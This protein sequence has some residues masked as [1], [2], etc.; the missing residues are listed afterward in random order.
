LFPGGG[1]PIEEVQLY[2]EAQPVTNAIP[3]LANAILCK[4]NRLRR[5]RVARDVNSSL[6]LLAP[7]M[8]AAFP[9]KLSPELE[10]KIAAAV[11]RPK[12]PAR[13]RIHAAFVSNSSPV[14]DEPPRRDLAAVIKNEAPTEAS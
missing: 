8:T 4:S 13:S 12:P 1:I 9:P 11:K 6:L 10:A 3:S 2:Y 14:P 7:E 5:R